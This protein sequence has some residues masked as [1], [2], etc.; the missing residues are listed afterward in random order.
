L[1]GH[2]GNDIFN[3]TGKSGS[4]TDFIDGGAGTNT[5]SISYDGITGLSDFTIGPI[6]TPG[7]DDG[8]V[9]TLTDQNGGVISFKNILEF[10]SPYG[11]GYWT[12]SITVQGNEY[13]YVSD[14]RYD[15]T[16]FSGSYGSLQAFA[17]NNGTVV[18]VV[19]PENGK[20]YGFSSGTRDGLTLAGTE[21]FVITGSDGSESIGGGEY[22]DVIYGGKGNDY[23][24][25]GDGADTIYAGEGDDVVYT[26]LEGLTEDV[27]IDG[28]AGNNTIAFYNFAG[29]NSGS[30]TFNAVSFNLSTD[31]GNAT[32]FQNVVGSY[33]DDTLTGDSADN[34]IIGGD[35]ADTLSGG[36]GNDSLYGDYHTGDT[37]GARYGFRQYGSSEGADVLYGQEGD[38]VLV[39]TN[40]DDILDGGVGQ[41]TLTGGN[42][43]DTF[44]IRA[45]E[46][47]TSEA[48]AD[49]IKD[50][51][52]DVDTV[53]LA[54]GLSFGALTVVQGEGAYVNDVLVKRGNEFLLVIKNQLVADIT[55]TDFQ[56]I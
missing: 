45:N 43:S 52:N 53:G 23:I 7:A 29:A 37:G 56:G 55:D 6:L 49:V 25:G 40:G 1:Y 35:G 11:G 14:M 19:L 31:L 3:I 44:V 8:S 15:K 26:A 22:G 18:D 12:G 27:L 10:G 46:G 50:F 51:Q 20:W 38:D 24:N 47:S 34:V 32:N 28:G 2:G 21:S 5:L 4:F 54:D 36:A 16:P 48:T 9:F 17:Y 41:D 30:Q 13:R 33:G 39:G 42:G